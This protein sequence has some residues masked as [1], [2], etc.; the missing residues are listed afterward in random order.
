MRERHLHVARAMLGIAA[1]ALREWQNR[2]AGNLPLDLA[3]EQ[4]ALLTKCATELERSTI[5]IDVEHRSTVINVLLGTHRYNDE[6][7]GASGE[8]EGEVEWKPLEDV[9]REQYEKLTAEEQAVWESWKDPPQKKL[10]N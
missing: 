5:G 4:I 7:A 8:V 9:E 3:P 6:K 10:T 1:H 2:I